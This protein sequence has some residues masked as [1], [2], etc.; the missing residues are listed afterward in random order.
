MKYLILLALLVGCA[1]N[2]RGVG[3]EPNKP[4]KKGKTYY[5]EIL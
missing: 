3:D 2:Y 4:V 1:S 5:K